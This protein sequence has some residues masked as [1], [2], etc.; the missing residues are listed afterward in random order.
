MSTTAGSYR[1]FGMMVTPPVGVPPFRTLKLSPVPQM[2][3]METDPYNILGNLRA[4]TAN[5]ILKAFS[6]VKRHEAALALPIY[7]H[8]GTNDKLADIKVR[9]APIPRGIGPPSHDMQVQVVGQTLQEC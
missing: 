1:V 7:A 5:E 6:H 3:L 8:H 9:I 4:R 2:K